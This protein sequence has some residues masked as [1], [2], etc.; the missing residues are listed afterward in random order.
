MMFLDKI[1]KSVKENKFVF[2]GLI[3]LIAVNMIISLSHEKK[4]LETAR[5]DGP[6]DTTPNTNASTNLRVRV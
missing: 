2:I 3:V 6:D 4:E 1:T 5:R